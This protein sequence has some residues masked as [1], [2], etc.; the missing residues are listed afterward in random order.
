VFGCIRSLAAFRLTG[1]QRDYVIIGSD[2][3]RIVILDY[4]KDKN[5][6]VKVHQETFGRSGCRRIVPGQYVAADPKGRACIIGALEKQKFVYVLNR[7]SAANLTISSP[8][9]AHKSHN[10]CF[11]LTALDCGFDN[12]IFAAIELDYVDADQ[13]GGEGWERRGDSGRGFASM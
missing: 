5:T 7:D 6:F 2:S 12:P 1:A 10:I 11:A 8:L 9:E 3:G 13:V 4:N